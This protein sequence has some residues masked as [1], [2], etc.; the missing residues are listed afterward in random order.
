MSHDL[1]QV[2]TFSTQISDYD[3]HNPALLNSLLA[4]NPVFVLQR[5]SL[6]TR[7]LIRLLFQFL[8]AFLLAQMGCSFLS[9]SLWL[10]PCF[11]YRC[12][13]SIF[14][15]LEVETDLYIPYRK[16]PIEPRLSLSFHL[17]LVLPSLIS[18]TFFFSTSS[19]Y[20]VAK[21]KRSKMVLQYGELA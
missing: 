6:R 17:L 3:A 21:L 13:F 1:T 12:W 10:L 16:N 4:S 8:L 9:H 20:V 7:T 18:F 5:P 19:K 14:Y 15:W 11:F 2:V